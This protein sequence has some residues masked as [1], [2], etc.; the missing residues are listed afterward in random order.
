MTDKRH[1]LEFSTDAELVAELAARRT[2]ALETAQGRHREYVE[3]VL[4]CLTLNAIDALAPLHGRTSCDD[5]KLANGWDSAEDGGA[6]CVRCALLESLEHQSIP[7]PFT[8]EVAV[9]NQGS[10]HFHE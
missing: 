7:Y 2:R 8:F 3:T 1:S 4:D 9:V 6:R 10:E 5:S